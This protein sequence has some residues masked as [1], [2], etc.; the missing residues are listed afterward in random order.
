VNIVLFGATGTIGSRIL[1]ELLSRRHHMTAVV[2]N[3]A[4]LEGHENVTSTVADIF[5]FRDVADAAGGADLV[6]SAYGPGPTHPE[7]LTEA[8]QS[9]IKGISAAGVRRLLMV[10][11]A[12]SLEVSPGVRLVDTPDFP[13]DWK[14]IALAHADALDILKTS[15]LNWTSASP[16][17]FIHPG[18]RT[19]KFRLGTDQ[20]IVNGQ[21]ASEISAEDFAI[22]IADEAE[23]AQYPRRRF[24]AAW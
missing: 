18:E 21:G 14:A 4:K 3:P 17:A 13:A 11:G 20:L 19:G 7:K 9:L 10:G 12:G 16:A 5:D 15:S 8:V 22:A 6:I 2:R 24:T 23:H 1:T